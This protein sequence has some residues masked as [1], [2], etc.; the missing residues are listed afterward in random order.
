MLITKEATRHC[1][2]ELDARINDYT[3]TD[4]GSKAI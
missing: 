2:D 3:L 4:A 1:C